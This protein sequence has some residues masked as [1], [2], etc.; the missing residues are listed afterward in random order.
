MHPSFH[1]QMSKHRMEEL[2][3]ETAAMQRVSRAKSDLE[4]TTGNRSFTH[5]L[6]YL[7]FGLSIPSSTQKQREEYTLE[8]FQALLN[9]IM[10]VV[11][12][13]ALGLGLLI[14]GFLYSSFGSLPVVLLSSS[15][16]VV[17]SL[18]ILL[19]SVSVLRK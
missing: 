6:W 13:V 19:R 2:Q 18:P 16:L 14:G 10:R 3:R 12:F 8:R 9:A 5:T 15:I 7:C 4:N 17:V 11:G 1:E